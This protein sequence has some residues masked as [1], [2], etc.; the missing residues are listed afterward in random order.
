[1]GVFKTSNKILKGKPKSSGNLLES[2]QSR[3]LK[4]EVKKKKRLHHR[5]HKMSRSHLVSKYAVL[6]SGTVMKMKVIK[7]NMCIEIL[8]MF[9]SV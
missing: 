9:E 4:V 5:E 2:I 1:M 3:P 7:R 6:E 8:C